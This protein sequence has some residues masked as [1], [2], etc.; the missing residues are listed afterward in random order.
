MNTTSTL[1]I[2]S[3]PS[4]AGK[5]SLVEALIASTPG[6]V[7]SVSHT[8]R[9]PRPGERDGVDYHFTDHD[10]FVAMVAAGRFLEHAE[11]FDNRY[12]TSVDSVDASLAAGNDVILVI[13]WQGAGNVRRQ[14]PDARSI[15]IVPPSLAALRQRL[16]GRGQDDADVIE[17][18]L[19]KARDEMGH[20]GDF[21][22]LVVN[23]RF[24][25]ACDD[26]RHIVLAQRLRCRRQ[27][28]QQRALL[29][30]LLGE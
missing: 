5:T 1:Y 20:Y 30:E 21:D 13:D 8:T 15:F 11:V 7:R 10:G 24:E 6:I 28:E 9:A 29:D 12:G 14:R 4:G 19:A 18:R 2:V 27:A 25:A 3:A 23:D 17:R 16:S 26:L 22:Y